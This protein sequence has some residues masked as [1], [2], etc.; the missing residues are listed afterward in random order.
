MGKNQSA[1]GLTNIIQYNN[2][3]ITFVSGSTV[4]MA[5]S[6]SGAITTTGVI[7]GSD[8]ANAISASFAQAA[9]S[10]SFASV[11]TSASFALNATSASQAQNAVSSSFAT[12]AANA[13]LLDSKDSTEFAITGSNIF[14]GIQYITDTSNPNGF[15]A[16]ASIYTDGG[17]RVTKDTYIS[18]TMFVNNLTVFGTQSINYITSSQLNISTNIISV[19]TDTPSIRFGGL[20]VY[21]SGST[22]LT[23]SMLWD[24]E[25]D[26]WVYSNPSGSSYSGGMIMSGPRSAAL[27]SE[28][29]TLN[30]YVM[31]GQG[32]DHITSSQIIDDGTTVRIPGNLQVTGSILSNGGIGIGTSAITSGYSLDVNGTS[33]FRSTTVIT[34]SGGT[35]LN[36]RNSGGSDSAVFV[37]DGTNT[38]Y[39]GLNVGSNPN[40]FVIYYAADT[41]MAIDTSGRVGFGT[42]SPGYNLEI[43]SG[44]SSPTEL[45]IVNTNAAGA[46]RLSLRNTE[47]DF[48]VTSNT[49]DDLLSFAYGGSNRLQFNTTNQWFN[50][51]NVGIGT[52]SPSSALNVNG[53]TGLTWAAAGVS[54]GL[55]TIG[56]PLTGGSLFVNTASDGGT[57]YQSGLGI[58]GTS[59]SQISTINIKAFGVKFGGFWGSNLAFHVS[60]GVS[61]NEAMRITSGGNVGIGTAG[62]ETK[63]HIEGSTAI[64]TTG[65][66][67]I[68]LLGRAIGAG[69]SFQQAAALKLGR[70]QNAGGS[71][72]SYTRLDFALRDNSASSNYN[73]NTTVMTLTNASR[74][75]IGVTN[76][77]AG[78]Q[79]A[80]PAQDDQLTLGSAAN[81]RD[82]AAFIYSGGN[83][84]EF[85]RYQS[86]V[87]LIIGSSS[88]IQYTDVIPGGSV[89]VR[90][91]AG[92]TSWSALTSDERRKKNFE[93][94]P[95][96]EALLQINPVKYHFKT[97]DDS[98]IKKL[99]FIAQN[100]QP[101]IPEMVHP[102]GEKAEDGTDILTIIPDYILPVLVKAIQELKAE[103]ETLKAQ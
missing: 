31:K 11:A 5:I 60:N 97:Q 67:S 71:F 102:N 90:L 16:S 29:G 54:S 70:Y 18:G 25:R 98:E 37:F 99:G 86:G 49:A 39:V 26:H 53:T 4:L 66:E 32:G 62:P 30:N 80:A 77:D 20:S 78:L 9:T 34:G 89:G 6:S 74:V 1:S 24:S 51:G 50:S 35:Y 12:N 2:S 21:D 15:G 68:L 85:L 44:S 58:D 87:R 83:K 45:A 61:L 7:S 63:L 48:I 94:V 46:A 33:Y 72:E 40:K 81:N 13:N 28:Q 65:T 3:G 43:N 76:P 42:S 8:A 36:I 56:T 91:N 22:G 75:G 52:S 27:G 41:R 17:L 69:A 57:G 79:I 84:A 88:N 96:L 19:N 14:T 59:A 23:G 82:H 93:T 103:I 10:A 64:G 55:V 47:R 38:G 101:L 95:G 100:I 92:N 73:T